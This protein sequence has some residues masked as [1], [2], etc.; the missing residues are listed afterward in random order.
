MRVP[1]SWLAE[2]V[3]ALPDRATT[4][5]L[6][7][8]L[9]LG[10]ETVHELP[11]APAGVEVALVLA[12]E[13]LPDSDTLTHVRLRGAGGERR[14]VC[15]APNVRVGMRS[16]Y[17]PP[18]V[19]LPGMQ[20][21][22]EVLEV[23]GAISEGMLCSPR[24]LGLYDS[25]G[26]VIEVAEDAPVGAALSDLWPGDA[27]IELE[28]TPNRADAFSL[29][30][31][32]RD[33]AAKLGSE[34][35]H[36]AAALHEAAGDPSLD[37]GLEVR[38]EDPSGCPQMLLRRVDGVRVGPSPLWMQRRLAQLGLRPRNV[39]VDATNL[40][41]FEL[42][43]PSHAYDLRA[44]QGGVL[45]VRRAR[46]DEPF[47]SLAEDELTL[48]AE[49][50]VIAT[51]DAQG[52][53]AIG[54]A[55]VIGGRDDS[56]RDDTESVAIEVAT[57]EPTGIRRTARRHKL[58]TDA[59]IRFERGVDPGG[60]LLACARVAELLRLHAG[61]RVHPGLSRFAAAATPP[62]PVRYRPSQLHFLMDLEVPAAEQQSI[63]ERLGFGVKRLAEDLFEVAVPSW[64]VDVALE[65][66]LIEEVARMHGYEHIGVSAA[67]LNFVPPATDPT[68]RRLRERLVGAGLME[69]IGYVF[70][71]DEELARARVAPASVRLA[72]PQGQERAVLRTSLLPGLLGVARLNRDAPSLA[73]FEVGRVFG[74]REEER[75]GILWR[76]LGA[77][78]PWQRAEPLS[79]YAAKGVLEQLAEGFGAELQLR[80]APFDDLHPG[81]SAEV[82]WDGAVVGRF[83]RVHPEVALAFECG[84]VVFAELNLPLVAHPPQLREV[85]RQPYAERDLALVTDVAVDYATLRDLCRS[86]AG[87]RLVELFP[88]DVYQGPQVGEGKKSVALRFRFRHP[89]RALTDAE[90]DAQMEAVMAALQQAGIGWRA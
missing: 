37:D 53:H 88:F 8:G 25:A 5:E 39:V 83:G 17:A 34:L 71:G 61:G 85:P 38:V 69:T 35:V 44:L 12:V 65:V 45:E 90:V 19:L 7:A 10:V 82:L 56:V 21:P 89:Q 20:A 1:L 67:H 13:P 11:A 6:L 26:G 57:F 50:L 42:G 75:L 64:R 28:L 68:H 4:V 62:A 49:D 15:G 33:L 40:V 48:S 2:L 14:V 84:E 54:L 60:A 74:E 32:A 18:G 73:I 46:A 87:E 79:L 47:V 59:R 31:V 70:T 23:A 51:P 58:V 77:S 24:E 30:G 55:G 9:G 72:E 63:L 36:P 52:S 27:V 80:P 16:A 76:G 22:L 3:P 86:A 41:T 43:Q 66:D 81:I 29:L 78:A